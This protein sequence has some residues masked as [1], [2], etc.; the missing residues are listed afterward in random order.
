MMAGLRLVSLREV[1]AITTESWVSF[2]RY[3]LIAGPSLVAGCLLGL[4]RH[5]GAGGAVV[6]VG[7][8]AYYAVVCRALAERAHA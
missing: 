2:R 8:F 3:L 5:P 4:A 6:I 7:T 1:N